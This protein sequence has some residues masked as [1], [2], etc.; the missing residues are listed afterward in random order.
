MKKWRWGLGAG[1]FL[2]VVLIYSSTYTLYSFQIAFITQFG[3]EVRTV[4]GAEHSGINFKLPL[5][6]KVSKWST[7]IHPYY[8]KKD[9]SYYTADTKSIIIQMVA[10]IRIVSPSVIQRSFGN[11]A[12][13]MSRI[14]DRIANALNGQLSQT[15]YDDV[16]KNKR[17][18]M[19][20]N[21]SEALRPLQES[22]GVD[23]QSILFSDV[24]PMPGNMEDIYS[25]MIAEAQ[26]KAKGILEQGRADKNKIVSEANRNYEN[27]VDEALVEASREKRIALEESQ[28][29][30]NEA[31]NGLPTEAFVFLKKLE[32]YE[33]L[34]KGM[35]IIID[36]KRGD[37]V[38]GGLVRP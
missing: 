20:Q 8:T 31:L 7:R 19:L 35:K 28:K 29:R 10:G 1:L 34:P 32:L 22:L 18:I 37:S 25:S 15:N 13:G 6:Q 24:R 4:H 33:K 26:A 36:T 38:F 14:D 17:A 5:I 2:A 11:L 21:I 12:T 16:V 9:D 30:I 23:V 27:S 3:K